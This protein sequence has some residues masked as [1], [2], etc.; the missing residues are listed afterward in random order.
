MSEDEW[1]IQFSLDGGQSVRIYLDG[2]MARRILTRFEHQ[3]GHQHVA[4]LLENSAADVIAAQRDQ[5]AVITARAWR[6]IITYLR[7]ATR[8]W[9]SF[10]GSWGYA[11]CRTPQ[12]PPGIAEGAARERRQDAI[13]FSFLDAVGTT[14]EQP[15]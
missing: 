3:G 14:T 15:V 1:S 9:R 13:L 4:A 11:P 10:C 2:P 5:R 8:S 7:Q 12:I 6:R